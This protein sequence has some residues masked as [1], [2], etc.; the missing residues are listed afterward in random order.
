MNFS[1]KLKNALDKLGSRPLVPYGEGVERFG[2]SSGI[3]VLWVMPKLIRALR[4]KELSIHAA[5]A[6][7]GEVFL[8]M[9]SAFRQASELDGARCYYVGKTTNFKKRHVIRRHKKLEKLLGAD[10]SQKRINEQLCYTFIK[11]NDWK[12]RFFLECYVIAALLPVLNT[13][14]ER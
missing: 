8:D 11:V 2:E 3:Y 4:G 13:Q 14:P 7:D 9:S 5:K 6:L 12:L 1:D 10:W